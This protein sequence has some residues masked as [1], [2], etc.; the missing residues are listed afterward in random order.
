MSVI[1]EIRNDVAGAGLLADWLGHGGDPVSSVMAEQRASACAFGDDGK[2][3]AMNVQPNWWDRV[4]SVIANTIRGQLALK[5]KMELKVSS[6]ENL[7][8]CRACGC[9]L[10][11]KV[12]VPIE[13][14]KAQTKQAVIDKTVPFCW[15]RKELNQ[16]GDV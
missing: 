2:P 12:W 3:C 10:P 5:H 7:H 15:M 6:E 9:A 16:I 14:L 13:T 4:K 1:D 8:M 11:L